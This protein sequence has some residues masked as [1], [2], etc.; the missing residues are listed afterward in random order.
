MEKKQTPLQ[1]EGIKDSLYGGF[2][3]RSV[4]QLFDAIIIMIFVL[5]QFLLIPYGKS[6]YFLASIFAL[7]FIFLYCIYLPKRFGGTPGKLIV[8]LKIIRID[9]ERIGWKEAILRYCIYFSFSLL[10]MLMMTIT[11]LTINNSDYTSLSLSEKIYH[12]NYLY[13]LQPAFLFI[14]SGIWGYGNVVAF[15]INTRKRALH[16]YL[17]KT[18]VVKTKYIEQIEQSLFLNE[19]YK[20][21]KREKI[22]RVSKV[23]LVTI[24]FL[25]IIYFPSFL[26]TLGS[27][28]QQEGLEIMIENSP[29]IDLTTLSENEYTDGRIIFE[30]PADM[31]IE[32]MMSDDI[33]TFFTL[34]Q[35][36]ASHEITTQI[37]IMSVFDVTKLTKRSFEEVMRTSADASFAEYEYDITIDTN[38]TSNGNIYFIRK[39][40]YYTEPQYEWIFAAISNEETSKYFLL[41]SWSLENL[42]DEIEQLINSVKFQN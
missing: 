1:I 15:F 17:A 19:E 7:L 4:A 38:Y 36:N 34:T 11:F 28:M 30:K 22:L 23:A 3:K 39:L 14:I 6:I 25:L 18:V 12:L 24:Y 20:L 29:Q 35:E 42:D 8:G 31:S 32:E 16:D 10:Y 27:K 26:V 9:G 2:W 21:S 33:G 37:T 40:E 13:S 5:V 41:S